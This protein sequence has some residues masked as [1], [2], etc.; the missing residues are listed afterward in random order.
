M[1]AAG[2]RDTP[3]MLHAGSGRSRSAR[4]PDDDKLYDNRAD[5]R[6]R[7]YVGPSDGGRSR[8]YRHE[9]PSKYEPAGAALPEDPRIS[10]LLRRLCAETD[11]EKSLQLCDRLQDAI[12]LPD[13]ARYVQRS[14]V[15]LA[16][17]LLAVLYDGPGFETKRAAAAALGRI[18]YVTG[19]EFS[20]HLDWIISNYAVNHS[21]IK[22]LL[23][24]SLLETF[25]LDFQSCSLS[26]HVQPMLQHLQTVVEGTNSAEVFMAAVNTMIVLS[27][28]YPESFSNHFVD[29]VDILVG[30]HVDNDQ[31]KIKQFALQSLYKLS[32]HWQVNVEFSINLLNHFVEDMIAYGNNVD[33]ETSNDEEPV[34]VEDSIQKVTSLIN[35][36]NTVVKSLGSLLNPSVSQVVS[37]SFLTDC[38]TKIL[39]VMI[40][41]LKEESTADLL[42]A[43]ND[44]ISLILEHLQTKTSS[45][46]PQLYTLVYLELDLYLNIQD[47][48]CLSIIHLIGKVIKNIS[49]NLLLEF[50]TEIIGKKS[51]V[52]P[53]RY[54]SNPLILQAV[55]TVYS[56]LLNLKNIPLLQE[57]YKYVLSDIHNSFSLLIP[58][59]HIIQTDYTEIVSKEDAQKN[60]IFYLQCLSDL[61][62]ASNSIIG[63]WAL[64]PSILELLA[65]KMCPHNNELIV[66]YPALHYAITYLL[67]SHCKK[68]NHF[69]ASSDL[70]TSSQQRA[71]DIYGFANLTLG[72]VSTSSPTSGHLAVIL[73]LLS[74]MLDKDMYKETLLLILH[75]ISD[76]LCQLDKYFPLV[77]MTQGFLV[78]ITNMLNLAYTFYDDIVIMV[79]KNAMLLLKNKEVNWNIIILK[80]IATLSLLHMDNR[81]STVR[82]I[83]LQALFNL[84][85]DVVQLELDKHLITVFVT[86]KFTL[87]VIN[88][89]TK[90]NA[91]KDYLMSG[92]F[93]TLSTE[94][95]KIIS[96]YLLQLSFEDKNA[97]QNAFLTFWPLQNQDPEEN[98]NPFFRQCAMSFS[99]IIVGWMLSELAQS[100]VN[101]KLR[102]RLGKPQE[103]FMK[104]E[105]ALKTIARDTSS[106]DTKYVA[107]EHHSL[108]EV[109][110][111]EQIR[112]RWVAEFMIF[113]EKYIYNAAEG[114]AI[115]L[116]TIGKPV[117]TFFHTNWS[118]CREWLSRVRPAALAVSLYAG[119]LGASVYHSGLILQSI[120]LSTT[121]TV[122]IEAIAMSIARVVIKLQEPEVLH[123]LYVWIK[124]TFDKKYQWLKAAAEQANSR[125]EISIDYYIKLTN[126]FNIQCDDAGDSISVP[127]NNKTIRFINEQVTEC[128][129][130]IQNWEDMQHWLDSTQKDKCRAEWQSYVTLNMYENN[131]DISSELSN[132]DILNME[133]KEIPKNVCSSQGLINKIESTL[134][135]TAI[136][137]TYADNIELYDEVLFECENL[138]KTNMIEFSRNNAVHFMKELAVMQ[139]ANQGLR[140]MIKVGK[141]IQNPF[142]PSSIKDQRLGTNLQ[143]LSRVLWWNQY[144]TKMNTT[145]ENTFY[146][147]CLRLDIVKCARKNSNLMMAKRELMKYFNCN[148]LLQIYLGNLSSL[149]ELGDILIM[150]TNTYDMDIWSPNNAN[151]LVELCKLTYA[152]EDVKSRAINLCASISLGFSQR[153]AMCEQNYEL[154][155][156]GTRM[157][158]TLSKWVQNEDESILIKNIESPLTKLVTALPE[159]GLVDNN[160]SENVIPLSDSAVGKLLQF[161]VNQCPGLAKAW[162]SFASWCFRWGRKMVEFSSKTGE[163]LTDND[164]MQIR[165]VMI[166]CSPQDFEAVCEILSKTKA[167]YDDEEIDWNEINTSEMIESQLRTVPCLSNAYPDH[168]ILLVDIWKQAQK[169]VFSYYELSADAYFKFLQLICAADYINHSGEYAVVSATLRLLRLIVKHAMELQTVLESGLANTPTQPWKVI[170][171]QLFSRLNHPEKYVRKCVSDLLCRL[172]EDTPHLITFPAVVGAVEN[173]SHEIAEFNI[174]RTFLS[175]EAENVGQELDLNESESEKVVNN[176]LNSCFLDMVETLANQAPKTILQVK[177]LV[178]ELQRI[179]LLWDELWLGTLVQHHTEFMKKL[180]HLEAEILKVKNNANLTSEDKDNLIK[181]KYRIIFDPII[182]VLQ[183]LNHIT[184][185]KPETPHEFAFQKKFQT[186]IDDVINKLNNPTNPDKPQESWAPLKQLQ[187]KFHQKVNRRTSYILKMSDISPILAELNNTVITMPG[188]HTTQRTVRVTIKSVENNVAIL[189]TK[190]RPKKLV[191]RGSD[192]K[193]YI[194]LFKGLEDLHLDERIMQ[195]LSIVNT[196]MARDSENDCNQTYRARHYSVIPLGPRSGLIS[197][198]DN[199]TPLFALYKRWQN[200]EAAM[201]S[202]KANKTVSVLR[203]SEL[204]YNKLN[205][206]LKEAGIPFENRKEWPVSILKQVLQELTAETPKDLLW[207]ELWCGSVSP[208]HWWR[209]I[210]RYS[211]SVAVMST[212]GYIIGLGD[213]HLDNVLVDLSSG[214]V[215]HID[216]NVCFEKGKTL[217]VPEKV[218]F[219]MTPNLVTA[220]GVTGVEVSYFNRF[221]ILFCCVPTT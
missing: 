136:S 148:A 206:L 64:K 163:Q 118:T 180:T 116:P 173:E 75:W 194:Y 51:L 8:G 36:F 184:S 21:S 211:Y 186:L 87:N 185:A 139:L 35:V 74:I 6:I 91:F 76:I 213:R 135:N 9:W 39:E 65:V 13:N 100:C 27:N 5:D 133:T 105:S 54:S 119:H 161:S 93:T 175:N 19:P 210:R 107:T 40:K 60:I 174:A 190:T 199:V 197:W 170:I 52:R 113:L 7:G 103:T 30:W 130:H 17:S 121:T 156:K 50:I 112:S 84:P 183:Q 41:L 142:K 193:S 1:S 66:L 192:G 181:E 92:S 43:G 88:A 62:N 49:S 26:M 109:I 89:D 216:Y 153:L 144:F 157:L 37:W 59:I 162:S 15:L 171:P 56:N 70:V 68:N 123:G 81:N 10:K 24:L 18:G 23:T 96:D 111:M 189:P 140:D 176:E 154:R 145:E 160:V 120:N 196:M 198:V 122:D 187:I 110:E 45:C 28:S 78:L 221:Y 94:H 38:M 44:C 32:R 202:A 22:H 102:T 149:D 212:I 97:L 85:W 141:V 146:V 158:L 201:L 127:E 48:V 152:Q 179:N 137:M 53:L 191:F 200:R 29:T 20:H 219:R 98:N 72:D 80:N 209:T 207:R 16:D 208:E 182:Y 106:L 134:I 138:L 83:C 82:D 101:L 42:L 61:A 12:M 108:R 99:S 167:T 164:K 195:L 131:M 117:R 218:P 14:H 168:L 11:V 34:S 177:L 46:A 71:S 150:S 115:V 151:A 3:A 86:G 77:S 178:K 114:T 125:Y 90:I 31:Q 4:G 129:K 104:I 203:P 69:I 188:V 215:V 132:W 214:E 47:Q 166:G 204:F 33:T 58:D 147:D 79:M 63:M 57:T 159:I 169:R 165:S 73:N 2:V 172:A 124:K 205:P 143:N 95:F 67:Y 155:E 128:Y 25:Q 55:V 126:E 220:L 217:R